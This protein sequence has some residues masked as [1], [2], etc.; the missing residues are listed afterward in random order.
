MVSKASASFWFVVE[1]SFIHTIM[2]TYYACS[3]IGIKFRWKFVITIL[4]MAQFVI[5]LTGAFW[6]L[7]YCWDCARFEEKVAIIYHLFYVSILFSMFKAFY[8]NAYKKKK[9]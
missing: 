2:Y 9:N 3:V 8:D 6:Q 5:G 4:Q 7:W 1:N